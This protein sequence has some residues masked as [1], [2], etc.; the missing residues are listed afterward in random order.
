M[1]SRPCSL[2][3]LISHAVTLQTELLSIPEDDISDLRVRLTHQ[4]PIKSLHVDRV[5]LSQASI[6]GAQFHI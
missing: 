5:N 1:R 4:R 2:C 6:L 3:H